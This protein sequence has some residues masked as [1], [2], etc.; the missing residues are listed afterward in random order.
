V[1]GGDRQALLAQDPADRLDSELLF[2]E[3][4]DHRCGRSSSA[5]KKPDAD[6]KIGVP[7]AAP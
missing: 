3:L 7:G 4:D 1:L 5:A 6:D 2:D